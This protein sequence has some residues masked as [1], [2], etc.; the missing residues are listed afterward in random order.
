M[1][2]WMH[3]REFMTSVANNQL[4]PTQALQD[5]HSGLASHAIDARIILGQVLHRAIYTLQ[6]AILAL[7]QS[8]PH[9]AT[10]LRVTRA[11]EAR[12]H[13]KQNTSTGSP[14]VYSTFHSQHCTLHQQVDTAVL[15]TVETWFRF[16]QDHR[17]L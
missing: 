1:K 3:G 8:G 13:C 7:H 17:K 9:E 4:L 6:R 15:T 12:E 14:R 10:C 11:K 5:N 2:T 16:T